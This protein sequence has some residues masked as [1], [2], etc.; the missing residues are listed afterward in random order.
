[1]PPRR[2]CLFDHLPC[3]GMLCLY[4]CL[5]ACDS[6]ASGGQSLLD[7]GGSAAADGAQATLVDAARLL[8]IGKL[9]RRAGEAELRQ[10]APGLHGLWRQQRWPPT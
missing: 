3:G 10:G 6:N 1:M 9:E 2:A 4:C 8:L 7:W 5:V